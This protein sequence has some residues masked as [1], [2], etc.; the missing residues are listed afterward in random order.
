MV[1]SSVSKILASAFLLTGSVS[2]AHAQWN[3]EVDVKSQIS[4]NALDC[5]SCDL[6]GNDLHGTRLKNSQFSG[7]ILNRVNFSGGVIYKSDFSGAH[8]KKAFL[9]RVKAEEVIFRGANLN[10]STLT[11]IVV[12]NSDFQGAN[13]AGAEISKGTF[14]NT[15]LRG[16]NLSRTIGMTSNFENSDLSFAYLDGANLIG[17]EFKNAVMSNTS[18]GTANIS[19]ARFDGARME[20]A[21]LANAQGLTQGQLD[22]A[23]GDGKT[24]LPVDLNI[25]YCAE[26]LVE[27]NVHEDGFHSGM[28]ERD[29]EI[30]LRT[31]RAIGHTEFLLETAT[32]ETRR[33]LEK[34][35][36][37]LLA[38]Q[39]KIEQ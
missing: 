12:K 37:D 11:E 16:V 17:A 19:A 23:C 14:E 18:F 27:G 25:S 5:S 26:T 32:V 15:I 2:S 6:S 28:A 30:A 35:H 4:A 38:I 7:A 9:A 31:E 10:G 39:R 29:K 33:T 34:V 13:L 22:V 1:T 36:A 24:E 21:K 8:L 20:G 3:Y